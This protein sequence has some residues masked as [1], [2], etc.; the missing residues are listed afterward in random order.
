MK[1]LFLI[2]LIIT[3]YFTCSAQD[4]TYLPEAPKGR[5]EIYSYHSLKYLPLFLEK[6][7]DSINGSHLKLYDIREKVLD[8]NNKPQKPLREF[9]SLD[10][11]PYAWLLTY[12]HR[13]GKDHIHFLVIV[14]TIYGTYKITSGISEFDI[15]SIS[16]LQRKKNDKSITF[17][18]LST[19]QQK[20]KF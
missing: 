5:T 7:I 8:K 14:P 20:H 10:K 6:M 2:S 1:G 4:S 13:S 11:Y 19:K 3:N 16:T 12:L 18:N 9:R 15:D 17:I